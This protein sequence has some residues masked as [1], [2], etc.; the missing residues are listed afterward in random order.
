MEEFKSLIEELSILNNI[1]QEGLEISKLMSP[2]QFIL[3]ITVEPSKLEDLFKFS[4]NLNRA[5]KNYSYDGV[6]LEDLVK[7][8]GKEIKITQ[9]KEAKLNEKEA[10]LDEQ[11]EYLLPFWEYK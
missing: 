7:A 9:D 10:R 6:Y 4:L 8:I 2:T 1:P 5:F 3:N 11:I